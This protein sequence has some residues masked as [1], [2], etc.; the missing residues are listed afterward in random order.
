MLSL[1]DIS[2]LAD[3]PPKWVLNTCAA[4]GL[5]LRYSLDLAWRLYLTHRLQW[6]I[7]VPLARGGE[8]AGTIPR[9][10]ATDG[11]RM[12][13]LPVDERCE[14]VLS[15]DLDRL[16][17]SFAARRAALATTIAPR[18]RGRPATR[19]RDPVKAAEDWGLD[20]SLL[21]ANLR[22]SQTERL[23]QLDAMSS[24]RRSARRVAER[25]RS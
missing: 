6:A 11:L 16:R 8:I 19:R 14:I 22:R 17:S 25:R 13:E 1:S 2:Y 7:G 18:V 23:R 9:G 15:L 12:T 20:V 24:F 10:P 5:G 4:L 21:S 3:A